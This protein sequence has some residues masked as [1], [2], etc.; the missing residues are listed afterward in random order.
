MIMYRVVHNCSMLAHRR[1]HKLCDLCTKPC[2]DIQSIFYFCS[3]SSATSCTCPF[4]FIWHHWVQF[5]LLQTFRPA[6]SQLSG[7]THSRGSMREPRPISTRS[8]SRSV[9]LSD[10]TLGPIDIAMVTLLHFE[11]AVSCFNMFLQPAG[12][13]R[14]PAAEEGCHCVHS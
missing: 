14:E 2:G 13:G 8:S 1:M 10:R 3:S 4:P 6:T 7:W 12:S 9:N 11:G 5:S